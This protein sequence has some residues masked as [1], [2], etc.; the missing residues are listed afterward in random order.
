MSTRFEL[1]EG[2]TRMTATL[3]LKDLDGNTVDTSGDVSIVDATNWQVRY[4]PDASDLVVG[5]YH[6]RFKVTDGSGGI[7]YFPSD[8]WDVWLIRSVA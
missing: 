4:T 3:V 6:G 2:W 5:R 7:A 1:V 8:E